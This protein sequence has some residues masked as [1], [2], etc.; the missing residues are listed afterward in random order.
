MPRCSDGGALTP[1]DTMWTGSTLTGTAPIRLIQTWQRLKSSQFK[2]TINAIQQQEGVRVPRV[3]NMEEFRYPKPQR[4]PRSQCVEL[5]YTNLRTRQD[6]S[7]YTSRCLCVKWLIHLPQGTHEWHVW[8]LQKT[9]MTE[10]TTIEFIRD[11]YKGPIRLKNS[12]DKRTYSK[13]LPTS[14]SVVCV[15]S[16]Q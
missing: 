11:K 4:V 15:R 5:G 1:P 16:T 10:K 2:S 13:Q 14:Q 8:Q 3:S 6:S 9:K 12:N 7:L